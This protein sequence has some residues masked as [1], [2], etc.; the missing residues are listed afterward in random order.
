MDKSTAQEHLTAWEAADLAITSGQAYTI[1][2]RALTRVNIQ[3]IRN[4]ITYWQ[5]I[6]SSYTAQANGSRNPGVRRAVFK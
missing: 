2:N 5:R 4:Q 6:V 1:G 3:E